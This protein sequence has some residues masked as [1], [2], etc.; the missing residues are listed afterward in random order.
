[1][2]PLIAKLVSMG[3]PILADAVLR[4][5]KEVVEEKLGVSIPDSP[6]PEQVD[7][8]KNK[9][10]EHKQWLEE[11]SLANED[12]ADAR[13]LQKV[14]LQQDDLFAKRY[15][16]YLATWWS[17]TAVLYI[18]GITF[19]HVPVENIRVVDTVLGF[20]LGTVVATI[21]TYFYGSALRQ[22]SR[23]SDARV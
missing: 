3:L 10:Q 21:M 18:T 23:S 20:L 15:I 5:G 19:F 6:T 8:L 12:R 17:V 22:P 11:V 9:E 1:M 4:K 16:Y 13:S 2:A 7:V 14:A